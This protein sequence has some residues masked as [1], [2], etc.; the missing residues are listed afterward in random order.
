M[1][2]LNLR[3][4]SFGAPVIGHY[5]Y[6]LPLAMQDI[7]PELQVRDHFFARRVKL[8]RRYEVD[9]PSGRGN[10]F[11]RVPTWFAH[12]ADVLI[13]AISVL[14]NFNQSFHDR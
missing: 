7:C 10:D 11:L 1:I 14:G 8:S 12:G 6:H 13:L 2:D 3:I 9:C 5:D 4:I